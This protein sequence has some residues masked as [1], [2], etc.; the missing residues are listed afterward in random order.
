MYR[1]EGKDETKPKSWLCVHV[2]FAG[3]L[4]VPCGFLVF[5]GNLDG[6]RRCCVTSLGKPS[7]AWRL[8]S[9]VLR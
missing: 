7:F 3:D 6:S 2:N 9:S 5:P 4:S 8:P 1:C